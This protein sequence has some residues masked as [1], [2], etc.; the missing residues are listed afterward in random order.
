MDNYLILT[1]PSCIN[2]TKWNAVVCSG[3]YARVAKVHRI[4]DPPAPDSTVSVS[5]YQVFGLMDTKSMTF[6]FKAVKK[7]KNYLKSGP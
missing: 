1:H 5:E 7:K 4:P 6:F 3:S 2:V